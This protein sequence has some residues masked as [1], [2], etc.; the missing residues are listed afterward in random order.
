MRRGLRKYV[1]FWLPAIFLLLIPLV[2][3]NPY[4]LHVGVMV[5]LNCMLAISLMPLLRSGLINAAHASF[6]AI[7][8]Y[9]SALL[10]MRLGLNFWL[11]LIGAGLIAAAFAAVIGYLTLRIR[12]LFF[13]L[14]TFSFATFFQLAL[15]YFRSLTGGPD[16]LVGVPAPPPILWSKI[17]FAGK[18]PYYYLMF[19]L[20]SG[21]VFIVYSLWTT[22]LG[23]I[24]RAMAENE[25]LVQSVGINPMKYKMLIFCVMTFLAGV[26]GSFYAHYIRFLG[27][28]DFDVWASIMLLIYVQVGGLLNFFGA[29]VGAS[30]LTIITELFRFAEEWQPIFFGGLLIVVTLFAPEGM[31]GIASRVKERVARTWLYWRQEN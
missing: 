25:R 7:G 23:R 13:L 16:G 2:I 19:L 10:V 17:E 27:P 14:V 31:V 24:C 29:L 20:L 15:T 6:W 11:A 8:A 12:G 21:A 30:S 4:F 1:V 3:S 28:Q 22:K 26:A 18:V 9:S 5:M